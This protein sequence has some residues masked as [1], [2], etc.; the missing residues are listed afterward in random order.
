[1]ELLG[2]QNEYVECKI[3]P[4]T[5]EVK[6]STW[7]FSLKANSIIDWDTFERVFKRK[8]DSKRTIATLTKELLS[9][10]MDKKEK[11]QDFNQRFTAHL[12]NFSATTRPAEETL[13]EYYTS[14]LCP[15]ITMFVKR[16][17]KRTLLENYEEANKV[18]AE[19]DNITKHTAKPEVKT[20]SG[21]KPLLLTRPKEEHSNEL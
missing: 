10:R 14:A 3:F 5:F 2:V 7:F 19:L 9:L 12:S 11:V 1:M 15:S 4:H 16:A 20:F 21:Q 6:D 8:F 13:I 17:V 18:E